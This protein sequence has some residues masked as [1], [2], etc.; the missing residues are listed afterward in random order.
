M[1]DT[2]LHIRN[3]SPL[4]GYYAQAYKLKDPSPIGYR[5][6]IRNTGATT[7]IS[8]E[9]VLYRESDAKAIEDKRPLI[10]VKIDYIHRK[11]GR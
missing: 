1:P 7:T 8:R 2:R 4:K 5:E 9:L 11:I 3:K 6:E 10:Q